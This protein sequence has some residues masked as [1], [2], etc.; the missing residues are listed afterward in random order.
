MKPATVLSHVLVAVLLVLVLALSLGYV[1]GYP[2]LLSYAESG[3]MEPAIQEGDGFLLVPSQLSDVGVGDVVMF[4]AEQ[5]HGGDL[6]THRV[7]AVTD[8]GYI[9]QGDANPFTDQDTGE[10]AVTD[11]QVV[12]VVPTLGDEPVTVPR[13]G[14]FVEGSRGVV[15]SVQS[16]LASSLGTDAVVG[17]QGLA[18]ILFGLGMSVFALMYFFESDGKGRDRLRDRERAEL[19][20]TWTVILVAVFFLVFVLTASMVMQGG[21]TKYEIV[22]AESNPDTPRVVAAGES[23]DRTYVINNPGYI[24]VVSFVEPGGPN[25]DVDEAEHEHYLRHGESVNAT[26]TFTAPD[27]LGYYP[28][29]VV[30]HRYFAVLPP[31]MLRGLYGI[32]PWMP[33]AVI[34]GLA[35]GTF[36]VVSAVLV[37]TQ[38]VRTR[39]RGGSS[40]SWLGIGSGRKDRERN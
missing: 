3:S 31:S 12:G 21:S 11:A 1:L 34:N 22:S 14:F 30:E 33:L 32:H 26:V 18:Y 9:T 35:A 8:R 39:V 27:E 19:F 4:E 24:P 10:P 36:V 23:V 29:Y 20:S 2:V 13:L 16:F 17:T 6:T 37:G 7:V 28:M 15:A 38:P 25:V 5:V 40:S